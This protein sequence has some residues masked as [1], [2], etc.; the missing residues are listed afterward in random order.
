MRG[1]LVSGVL[2]AVAFLVP[3]SSSGETLTGIH[4]EG[5]R[6]VDALGRTVILRGINA[7]D[8][9]V[10]A[11]G[12]LDPDLSDADLD[13]IASIGFNS[14]RLGTSWAA[15]EPSPGV[16]DDAFIDRFIAQMDAALAHGL[17]VVVDIHQDVWGESLG[18][19]GAPAWAAPQC[20]VPPRLPIA[21]TTGQWFTQYG[22]PDVLAAFGNF[23]MDG[24]GD[25][26]CTGPIQTRFVEMFG[27]LADR[28]AGHP[29]LVGYDLL[30][31]PWP[32][33][34]PGVFEVAQLYP[35]YERL[36][37][38][39]R[40]VDP[41]TTIFFEPPIQK[42][43]GIPTIPVG[44]SDPNAV[45]APHT[46][47]ETMYSGGALTTDALTDEI[48]LTETM[49][50]AQAMG[51]PMWIGEWGAFE[52]ANAERYHRAFYG[53][54]DRFR[55][56]SAYWHY[57]QGYTDGLQAQPDAADA[58]HI[59]VYPEAFPGAATWTFDPE[60]RTFQMSLTVAEAAPPAAVIVVPDRLF[61]GGSNVVT[62]SGSIVTGSQN[63]LLWTVSG[64]GAHTLTI[65]PA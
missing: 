64:T 59:R 62:S 17:L 26:F 42:S 1:R 28:L 14:L 41:S 63:R 15:I 30:N 29:A 36:I 43:A 21:E 23:W 20:N 32:G 6:V 22:S 12:N 40:S 56:G 47:T 33:T 39:I 2:L 5:G 46:Y 9:T 45:F 11:D 13:R 48:V 4:S 38:E 7:M 31:E 10:G 25:V 55:I 37:A 61:P 60:T 65:K 18:G 3:M 35:F 53:L 49:L 19:N 52:N 44:V 50:E 51:V 16:Y 24:A 54:L 57:T 8:K 58:G 27:H 34:P